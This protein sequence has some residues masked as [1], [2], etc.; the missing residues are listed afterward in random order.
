MS[1]TNSFSAVN[2]RSIASLQVGTK[3]FNYHD[4]VLTEHELGKEDTLFSLY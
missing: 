1:L 3:L 2:K 4:D